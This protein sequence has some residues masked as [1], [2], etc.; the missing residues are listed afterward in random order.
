M[1]LKDLQRFCNDLRK[2]GIEALPKDGKTMIKINI[3]NMDFYFY[4]D[5]TKQYD[6]WGTGNQSIIE[7][8]GYK[9]EEGDGK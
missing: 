4:K 8:L 9:I 7:D 3:A 1:T 6:G 2:I 5:E